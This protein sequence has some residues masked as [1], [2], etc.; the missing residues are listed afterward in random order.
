MNINKIIKLSLGKI[1]FIFLLVFATGLSQLNRTGAWFL[2]SLAGQ[3]NE[4]QT[5][6]WV[7]S[8]PEWLK[9]YNGVY[10]H[11]SQNVLIDWTDSVDTD[12]AGYEYENTGPGGTWKSKDTCGLIIESQF[13]NSQIG[14]G[15]SCIDAPAGTFSVDGEYRRIVRAVDSNSHVSDWSDEWLLIRDTV[16]PSSHVNPFSPGIT[17]NFTFDVNYT[18]SDDKAGVKQ[19]E[20]FYRIDG[21]IW[22]SYGKFNS[23]PISFTASSLGTYDFYTIAED[24]ADDLDA[25][26]MADGS[27]GDNG[28]GNLET[29]S[30]LVEATMTV[31]APTLPSCPAGQQL[32][33]SDPIDR[34]NIGD[35][36]NEAGHN[37]I[38]WSDANIP[39]NYGGKDDKTYRQIVET[40]SCNDSGREATL[41]LHAGTG[42]V[43]LLRLRAL[44]GM[45]NLDSFDV[46][47]NDVLIGHYTDVNDSTELWHTYT[48]PLNNLTGDLTIKLRATDAIWP[49]CTTY[50]QVAISWVEVAGYSC[51]PGAA[52]N[53][54]LKISN[55]PAREIKNNITNGDF[56]TD[57]SPAW[58]IGADADVQRV[59]SGTDGVYSPNGSAYMVKVGQIGDPG[60]DIT[61]NTISQELA[62]ES[63]N[64]SFWY[65]FYTYDYH[66]YDEPGFAVYLNG[67]QIYQVWAKDIN[68]E[69]ILPD[70]PYFSGWHQFYYDLSSIDM[71]VNPTLTIAFFAGNTGDTMIQSWAYI[72]NI[73]TAES[74]VNSHALISLTPSVMA[75]TYYKLS[76]CDSVLPNN[77]YSGPFSLTVPLTNDTLCFWSENVSGKEINKEAHIKFD[78]T[79]PSTITDLSVVDL[80]EGK[81]IL[82]WT[83]PTD[84]TNGGWATD[85][86][87]RYTTSAITPTTDWNSLTKIININAPRK[88]GE[89]EELDVAGLNP[90]L[91]YWF[92]IKSADAAPNWSAIS[93]TANNPLVVLNE[94]MYNPVDEDGSIPN[95]EWV[96]LYN[97]ADYDIDVAG[98]Q[99]RDDDGHIIT[100][101]NS[102]SDNDLDTADSGET[103]VPRHAWLTVYRNGSAIFNNTGDTVS[104]YNGAHLIDSYTYAGSKS[105]GLTAARIPDGTGSWVDPLA[106][107]GRKNVLSQ[108]DLDPQIRIWQQDSN[109]AKIGIFDSVNYNNAEYKIIYSHQEEGMVNPQQEMI[110]GSVSITSQEVIVGD[111][112]FGSSSAGIYTAHHNITNVSLEVVLKGSGI[113]DRTLTD[114]LDGN[115]IQ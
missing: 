64:I 43:N 87:L 40:T 49:S 61:I 114:N 28:I 59:T 106:T 36:S 95:G 7:P 103:I 29:K 25:A 30:P 19:V 24:K 9:P 72:D 115:W 110:S 56:E 96:E 39:G 63:K 58:I 15:G 48:L 41:A 2:S 78:D 104:L 11:Q 26:Q 16:A 57:L 70:T 1:I 47:V 55:S 69:E 83:A 3:N 90:S 77:T 66:S 6:E 85:Y 93:N 68:L 33:P 27:N 20:L 112:Y 32:T 81:F 76:P 8:V 92:A 5:S 113:S 17:T 13:P 37:L 12:L 62:N 14:I 86:D 108:A 10:T 97:N 50:G 18:A 35:L 100:I 109:N 45:S 67:K 34:V 53:T 60:K 107:P 22:A 54:V 105:D 79:L 73:S 94:I 102:N 88:P 74:V 89:T 91:T 84:N 101:S 4:V 44:D 82:N 42:Q 98:W 52:I 46:Y 111:K 75:T 38:G 65:N 80:S 71:T 21:G 31:Q 23:F 51:Q 99:I